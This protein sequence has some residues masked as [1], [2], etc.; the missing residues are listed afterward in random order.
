VR[1][2][3]TFIAAAT[4]VTATLA[5]ELQCRSASIQDPRQSAIVVAVP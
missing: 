5:T 2:A 1:Q 3:Q 4:G